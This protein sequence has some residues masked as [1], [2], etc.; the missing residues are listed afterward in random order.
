MTSFPVRD[1]IVSLTDHGENVGPPSSRIR[2]RPCID[3]MADTAKPNYRLI[4]ACGRAYMWSFLSA[5]AP[6]LALTL[7]TFLQPALITTTVTFV[8]E[9]DASRTYGR[10]LI[11]AWALVYL[12]LAVGH[13]SPSQDRM[14]AD[15]DAGLQLSLPVSELSIRDTST[16]WID[17]V[18]LQ[19]VSQLTICRRRRRHRNRCHEHRCRAHRRRPTDIPR[20]VGFA[21]GHWRS[22]LAFGARNGPGLYRLREGVGMYS[23]E[24][25]YYTLSR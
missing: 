15:S 11:A 8:G 7:F 3:R 21:P 18:D 17:I 20:D 6:R 13:D 10:A 22:H 12:G 25:C 14:R 16:R 2:L 23:L 19:T 9:P 4:K 1:S 24:V 5:I